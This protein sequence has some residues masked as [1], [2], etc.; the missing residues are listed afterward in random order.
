MMGEKACCGVGLQHGH[1]EAHLKSGLGGGD[2]W[3][4][5]PCVWGVLEMHR[6][7]MQCGWGRVEG[8]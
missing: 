8:R 5:C 2:V 4:L 3:Q 7:E 6:L 1:R